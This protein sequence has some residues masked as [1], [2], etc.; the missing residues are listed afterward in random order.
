MPPLPD[1]QHLVVRIDG[2]DRHPAGVGSDL[3]SRTMAVGCLDFVDPEL[4]DSPVVEDLRRHE[5]LSKAVLG[6]AR[7]WLAGI[8]VW[9]A[10]L[11]LT[12]GILRAHHVA[13]VARSARVAMSGTTRSG[14]AFAGGVAPVPGRPWRRF[15]QTVASPSRF[16]VT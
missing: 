10:H 6:L 13:A 15:T 7:R 3:P 1:E 14:V 11:P 4:Q 2:D 9:A 8:V 12:G 16:A 5:S